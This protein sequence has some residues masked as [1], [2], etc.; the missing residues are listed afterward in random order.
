MGIRVDTGKNLKHVWIEE[1]GNY[2]YN[3]GK[4]YFHAMDEEKRISDFHDAIAGDCIELLSKCVK[5]MEADPGLY[6]AMNPE[7]G[8]GDYHGAL[9]YIKRFRDVCVEHPKCTV[10]VM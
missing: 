9:K 3:V 7:N 5:N 10:S 1:V 6:I 8:W 4:M 2:T